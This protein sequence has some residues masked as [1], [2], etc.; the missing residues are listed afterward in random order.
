MEN[1]K[2]GGRREGAGRPKIDIKRKH[3]A[4]Q[5]FDD[6]WELIRS[7]ARERE[8]SPREY[9]YS[10]VEHDSEGKGLNPQEGKAATPNGTSITFTLQ[11][12]LANQLPRDNVEREVFL[13]QCVNYGLDGF[14]P[15]WLS[16]AGKKGGSVKSAVKAAS[17]KENGKKGGRPK[18]DKEPT[19]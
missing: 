16:R 14:V 11:Q 6:E 5:F 4:L 8:K 3:R 19:I 7:K 15:E 9:L 12:E 2:R 13:T 17:S 18:K 1:S 10:L